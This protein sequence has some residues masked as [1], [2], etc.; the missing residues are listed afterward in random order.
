MA[1]QCAGSPG[2]EQRRAFRALPG[3]GPSLASGACH[4]ARWGPVHG[5]APRSPHLRRPR[6]TSSRGNALGRSR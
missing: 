6:P 4:S 3:A 2:G 5:R 1:G